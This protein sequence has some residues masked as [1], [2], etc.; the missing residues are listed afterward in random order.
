MIDCLSR[1]GPQECEE[2]RDRVEDEGPD[3]TIIPS[4]LPFMF[5]CVAGLTERRA[6]RNQI[7]HGSQPPVPF[8]P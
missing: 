3:R 6:R 1:K 5:Q 8:G 2:G 7:S 4:S